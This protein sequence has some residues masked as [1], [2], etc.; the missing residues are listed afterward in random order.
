MSNKI[1]VNKDVLFWAIA[2]SQRDTVIIQRTFPKLPQ[3][4]SAEDAPTFAQLKK[5]SDFLYVPFGFLFLDSPPKEPDVIKQFRTIN[6]SQLSIISKGLKDTLSQMKFISSW[7]SELRQDENEVPLTWVGSCL[8]TEAIAQLESAVLK[9]IGLKKG[10]SL[11]FRDPETLF[12][13]LRSRMENEG[14]LVFRNS[15]VGSNTRRHLSVSEFRAFSLVDSYAPVI[16]INSAD[17]LTGQIFS[18]IHEFTHLLIGKTGVTL[19][20]KDES[21]CNKTVAALLIPDELL[22]NKLPKGLITLDVIKEVAAQFNVSPLALAYCLLNKSLISEKLKD[23][24]RDETDKAVADK[25]SKKKS[26]GG[27]DFY[28][29]YESNI[30]LSFRRA[31][32]TQLRDGLVTYTTAS[33]LLGLSKS[34]TVI[35]VVERIQT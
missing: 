7:M 28:R 29:A 21:I 13:D 32:A 30:S 25:T 20:G 18:L 11:K 5:L 33:Q 26:S 2:E 4:L 24:V 22:M 35:K 15:K 10:F 9:V 23:K 8:D 14:V 31:V 16:F 12:K 1:A 17:S 19:P 3:W 27:P 6:S 34:A